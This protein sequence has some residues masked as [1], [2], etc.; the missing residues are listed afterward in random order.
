M[1][2][3]FDKDKVLARVKK[4]MT[5]ANDAA[6]S[7]GE[8]DNAL[9]MAHATLA[10]YNLTMA[11]ADASTAPEQRLR[12]T[13]E[14]KHDSPLERTVYAAIGELFFCYFFTTRT[15]DGGIRY[16]FVGKESNIY[17][18]QEMSKYVVNS[19]FA[20]AAAT[21]KAHGEGSRGTFWRS[22]CKGAANRVYD[23]CREIRRAAEQAPAASGTALVLASVYKTEL[24]ANQKFIEDE[25]HIKLRYSKS[26]ER[27]T[28][29]DAYYAGQRYGDRI[30][31][32]NQIGSRSPSA[33]R[34]ERK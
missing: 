6:A 34:L 12:G 22:F 5:L 19:I 18:A 30:G 8:R 7:E 28:T 23:R 17:T 27:N 13:M 20:E 24:L 26:R 3:E 10:K 15:R 16:T 21:A 9:R 14:R 31:L 1:T 11:E 25:L 32:N 4:M 2:S 29:A 33:G